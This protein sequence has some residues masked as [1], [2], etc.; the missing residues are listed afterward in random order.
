MRVGVAAVS[1]SDVSFASRS[2]LARAHSRLTARCVFPSYISQPQQVFARQIA[3]ARRR[4]RRTTRLAK[5][6]LNQQILESER[7]YQ[8]RSRKDGNVCSQWLR[9]ST[10][11]GFLQLLQPS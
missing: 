9:S 3:V 4:T 11:I 10:G 7:I 2:Q 1:K 8:S 6:Y 5:S